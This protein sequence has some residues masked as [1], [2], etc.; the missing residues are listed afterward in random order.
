MH[1]NMK[2][3]FG[4]VGQILMDKGQGVCSG[5]RWGK[6]NWH[7]RLDWYSKTVSEE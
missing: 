5:E 4:H 1:A 2:E 7:A 3:V 6:T